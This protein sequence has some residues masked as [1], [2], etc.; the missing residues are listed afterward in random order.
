M[1]Q[2]QAHEYRASVMRLY[3]PRAGGRGLIC[4]E[5]AW[6][7]DTLAVAIYLNINSN[8]QVRQAMCNTNLN[9][10][11]AHALGIGEK[12][13]LTNL[14]PATGLSQERPTDPSVTK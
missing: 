12:Y 7:T 2:S 8:P 5:H 1:R 3:L 4:L 14:L 9:G 13:N 11:V 10:L 6:E